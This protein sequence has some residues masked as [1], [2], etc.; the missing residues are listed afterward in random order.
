M[1]AIRSYYAW[2]ET[3]REAVSLI[4]ETLSELRAMESVHEAEGD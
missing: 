1:Y 4:E 2:D 3:R